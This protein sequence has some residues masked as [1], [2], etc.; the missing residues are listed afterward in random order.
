[1]I[2]KEIKIEWCEN[3]IKAF[4]RKHN[5]KGVYTKLMFEAAEKAGLYTRDTYGSNFS[6]ALENT[7]EVN[8]VQNANGEYAYSVFRLKEA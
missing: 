5:C 6:K 2:N 3:F 4:F 1:M 7:V 8:S